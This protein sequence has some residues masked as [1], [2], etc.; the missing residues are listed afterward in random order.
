M[1]SFVVL[2]AIILAMGVLFYKVM[3]GFLLPLFLAAL[4]VVIFRPLHRWIAI[5]CK[6][7]DRVAAGLTTAAIMLIVL[8]PLGWICAYALMQGVTLV[9]QFDTSK[10]Q[11]RIAEARKS[12]GLEM[13][14]ADQFHEIDDQLDRLMASA[15]SD[16]EIVVREGAIDGLLQTIDKL[17]GEL[18]RAA[19]EPPAGDRQVVDPAAA[20]KARAHVP[21]LRNPIAQLK[22]KGLTPLDADYLRNLKMAK[23]SFRHLR[24]DLLGGQIQ[25]FVIDLANPSDQDIENLRKQG[26]DRLNSWLLSMTGTAPAVVGNFLLGACIMILALYYF[27]VDGPVMV[28]T[29]MRLSPLDDR[30]EEQLL[31]EFDSISR[32]VVLATLLTAIVQ[33]I[34]AGIGFFFAGLDSVILLTLL[35]TVLALIPFIGAAAVWFPVCLWLFFIDNRPVAA[36][37]LGIY[38]VLIVS[39]ADNVI[40][41][42]VLHGRSNMHPL[43]ALL[44]VIGGVQA[45]GPIG[46]LVGPM[47]VAFLQALL[48]ILHTEL[49]RMSRERPAVEDSG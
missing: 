15:K 28:H 44:S 3:A 34:L 6:G 41:P 5:K 36:V 30:Y 9:T 17:D 27:L 47:I 32:A 38:G 12:V 46:I 31:G 39:M 24:Q 14:F 45:L 20:S 43:V 35:T 4:L 19:E 7:H 42:L 40:K 18:E 2:I 8:V 48:N 21:W 26:F 22:E 29:V 23:L 33:G 10:F 25:A 11:Q 16:G 37:T 1:V 13:P 49:S